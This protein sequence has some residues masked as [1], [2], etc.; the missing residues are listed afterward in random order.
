MASCNR[1]FLLGNVTRD[2]ELR[3]IP[4]GTAVTEV[5]V[6]VNER[7]K[8]GDQWVE[9]ATFVDVTVWGRTAEIASEY[10]KRGSQVLFEGK[11][12]LETWEKD[13]QKRS[14]LKVVADNMQLLGSKGERR[15]GPPADADQSWGEPQVEQPAG[16]SSEEIPF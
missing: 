9:E 11:L 16:Y 4:S 8:R 3:H 2:P 1:V 14:K 13:G 12:R 5:G 15:T 6:A 7:V 10:L